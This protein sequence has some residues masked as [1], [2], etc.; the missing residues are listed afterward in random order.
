MFWNKILLNNSQ[1]EFLMK[2]VEKPLNNN[3]ERENNKFNSFSAINYL[4]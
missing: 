2:R 4:N 1:I 3:N